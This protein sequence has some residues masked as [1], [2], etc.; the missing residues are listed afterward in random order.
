MGAFND[1][2]GLQAIDTLTVQANAGARVVTP[3]GMVLNGATDVVKRGV[4]NSA[5]EDPDQ[6]G[7]VNEL[8][9]SLVDFMEFYLFNYF[10]PGQ[11]QHRMTI[12]AR[13]EAQ[14]RQGAE[15]RTQFGK[16]A[17]LQKHQRFG[18]RRKRLCSN[19]HD[20]SSR[21]GPFTSRQPATGS[22]SRRRRSRIVPQRNI[23]A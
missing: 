6:D 20:V 17:P 2:M 22:V 13:R 15:K 16:G 21:V 9:Q 12:A 5:Q 8:P 23:A 1:E 19:G 14:Q 11:Y 3:T 18:R 7:V 10:K 4:P